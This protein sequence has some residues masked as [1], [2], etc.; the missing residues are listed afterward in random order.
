MADPIF[1]EFSFGRGAPQGG[2]QVGRITH[3]QA[4][5]VEGFWHGTPITELVQESKFDAYY[6]LDEK[7][8]IAHCRK[9]VALSA[10]RALNG[11][12]GE[13]LELRPVEV[14]FARIIPRAI[15]V[16][17]SWFKGMSYSNIR[18]EAAFGNQINRDPE[19]ARMCA[20]GKHTNLIVVISHGADTLKV[21]LS[22][23]GSAYFMDN[24]PTQT[25][26]EFVALLTQYRV[27]GAQAA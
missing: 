14:D 26:L 23:D 16:I 24:T 17:G 21:N 5:H 9:E 6:R 19:F 18:S 20:L 11:G 4:V 1:T 15:T 2:F 8:L 7:I 27:A 3:R 12:F 10:V 25:C 22:R 13:V